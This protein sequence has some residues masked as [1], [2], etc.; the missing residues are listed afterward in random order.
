MCLILF[1]WK[2]TPGY[3]LV[4]LA[5]R[6]EFLARPT[7]PADFWTDHPEILGGRDLEAGGS[8]LAIGPGRRLAAVTNV[9]DPGKEVSNAVSR[10]HLVSSFLT[11]QERAHAFALGVLE[12]GGEYN[13]FNLLLHDGQEL[14]FVSNRSSE[15]VR[16][17]EPGLYGLSNADLN[18]P[19]PKVVSG[20]RELENVLSGNP[21]WSV[22]DLMPILEDSTPASDAD[23]PQTG[24]PIEWE[25]ILSAR[26][27]R[28]AEYGTRAST[29][30]LISAKGSV[31]FHEKA[32]LS[33]PH[34]V[35]FELI[36]N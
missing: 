1:S 15:G 17:L 11:S 33:E 19:W 27:I 7:L 31:T 36:A 25:R 10:G 12:R 21:G 26:C 8:W 29:V 16:V 2:E 35:T 34:E 18:T 23:L 13:G 3:D 28:S 24:V 5:N 32:H 20:K 6:D 9:R 4:L 30:V 14:V 22:E